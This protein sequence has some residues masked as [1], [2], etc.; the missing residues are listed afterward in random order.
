MVEDPSSHGSPLTGGRANPEGHGVGRR[1]GG[2]ST[3]VVL[4]LQRVPYVVSLL[5][6]LGAG[7][8]VQVLVSV[9]QWVQ[10]DEGNSIEAAL[11]IV[12]GGVP[13]VTYAARE[14][15]TFYL[16]AP[17]V[18][19]VG[20]SV[21]A[22]RLE[23]VAFNLLTATVL[24]LLVRRL[25][26]SEGERA[27][28]VVA[29][30]YLLLPFAVR[31]ETLVTLEP[32]S[33]FFLSV[34]T[35]FLFRDRWRLWVGNLP[36]AGLS[37]ALAFLA[38]RD[39]AIVGLAFL[40]YV[41]WTETTWNQRW[42]GTFRLLLPPVLLVG[43]YLVVL[44]A[45][46]TPQWVL[47]EFGTGDLA[48][49]Q[50]VF[51]WWEKAASLGFLIVVAAPVALTAWLVPSRL[52]RSPQPSKA[53]LLLATGAL[54]VVEGLLVTF[55]AVTSALSKLPFPSV[56]GAVTLAFVVLLLALGW[57]LLEG[58]RPY[59]LPVAPAAV[60]A[61]W[62][63]LFLFADFV[64][65]PVFDTIYFGDATAPLAV[66]S[67]CWLA[68]LQP[69]PGL[70]RGSEEDWS[71]ASPS[72]ASRPMGVRRF[73]RWLSTGLRR[74]VPALVLVSL[75]LLSAI[76]ATQ[77]YG[78]TGRVATLAPMS[79]TASAQGYPLPEVQKVA[80]LLL[81]SG[82]AHAASFSFDPV[83]QAQA[84][85]RNTPDLS[86]VLDAYGQ[87][88]YAANESPYPYDPKGLVPSPDQL[89][90]IW[91]D[92]S[93]SF[94]V[95]GDRTQGVENS[96]PI[97]GWYFHQFFHPI[98]TFGDPD[99]LDLVNV[100]E[101]GGPPAENATLVQNVS[102]PGTPSDAVQD[103]GSGD[104]FV[105]SWSSS[106]VQI[107][108]P[109]GT[110]SAVSIAP[111][112][113]AG[114]LSIVEG[115]LW[116]T[117]SVT[118]FAR[119]YGLPGLSPLQTL[120]LPGVA[121]SVASD[122]SSGLVWVGSGAPAWVTTYDQDPTNGSWVVAWGTG[123]DGAPSGIAVDPSLARVFVAVSSP[124]ELEV[125]SE[126]TGAL[127]SRVPLPFPP[128]GVLASSGLV[129]VDWWAGS[130]QVLDGR[131][132]SLVS[133]LKVGA[134]DYEISLVDNGSVLAALS[135]QAGRLSLFDASS[136]LPLGTVTLGGCSNA[137]TL[138]DPLTWVVTANFCSNVALRFALP[139]PTWV[140][141]TSSEGANLTIGQQVVPQDR[142]VPLWPQVLSLSATAPGFAPGA[143]EWTTPSVPGGSVHLF[144]PLGPSISSLANV[145]QRFQ[146]MVVIAS[147]VA[148]VGALA[149]LLPTDQP[150][151]PPLRPRRP[152][153]K[154]RARAWVAPGPPDGGP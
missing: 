6:V 90:S 45:L 101:R 29:A 39:A 107:I 116:V 97:F 92:T 32:V 26:P 7:A 132:G 62:G 8:C 133:T 33:A 141:F 129:Y 84:G 139:P 46:T 68:S 110:T 11:S 74:G 103:P 85:L 52:W 126:P 40:L 14:P 80:N 18:A 102:A 10:L 50:Q 61:L 23:I 98:G 99:S 118:P 55:L 88:G 117:S 27:G 124:R 59:P 35:F 56:V 86:V 114:A 66:L 130:V 150:P 127:L 81:R 16:L 100:L 38:R 112:T 72:G 31:N 64:A 12:S 87:H 82:A 91:N 73:E 30:L 79:P 67:G 113:G 60:M 2:L 63:A 153:P 48:Y 1:L 17:V 109:D 135:A 58:H 54:A 96:Y 136:L 20:G 3:K 4:T 134:E 145:E 24:A 34:G 144:V 105:S 43:S 147:L 151:S 76:S 41:L 44:A 89:L 137:F 77:V 22:A 9:G 111:F 125:L 94:V 15:G 36:V 78:P 106:T 75:L 42:R 108:H 83:F 128:S 19:V 65:R 51:P 70:H 71:R 146:G 131:T 93:L 120:W 140:T 25:A 53:T 122:P 57:G 115:E 138:S 47:V 69:P 21:L 119:L 154:G 142:S 5:L 121:T 49:G 148:G 28:L 104:V 149:L 152:A 143:L 95:E 37:V 13:M 123:I